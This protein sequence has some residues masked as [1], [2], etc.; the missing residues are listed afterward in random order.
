[1]KRINI[2]SEENHFIGCWNIDDNNLS[3]NIIQFFEENKTLQNQGLIGGG[4][5]LK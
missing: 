3:E 5:D 4:K 2:K 1:M